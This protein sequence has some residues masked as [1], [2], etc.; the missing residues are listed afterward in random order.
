MVT[1]SFSRNQLKG[2]S[3]N[4]E[5]SEKYQIE[6]SLRNDPGRPFDILAM[7][8]NTEDAQQLQRFKEERRGLLSD[9]IHLDKYP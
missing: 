7:S 6:R 8:M 2:D 9:E 5:D 3:D 4:D 1:G